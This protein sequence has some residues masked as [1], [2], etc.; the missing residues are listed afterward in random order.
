PGGII[1]F[2]WSDNLESPEQIAQL[3]HDIQD[4]ALSAGAPALSLSID[5]E[6]GVVERLPQ[7]SAQLPGA[8]ALGATGSPEYARQAAT[9]TAAELSALGINQNYSP[10]A[11]V[12]SNAQNPVIGVRAFG[13]ATELVS[14]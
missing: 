9:I 12:N 10:I 11:D 13:G 5:Q 14:D 7:P 3:P 8:M 6:E 1:Y 4:R 2:G